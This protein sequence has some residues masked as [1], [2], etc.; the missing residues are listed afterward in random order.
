[1]LKDRGDTSFE[2]WAFTFN[3]YPYFDTSQQLDTPD[4]VTCKGSQKVALR[5]DGDGLFMSLIKAY[6]E[7]IATLD[8]RA[9]NGKQVPLWIGETG[10][11]SPMA[12][13]LTG[14]MKKCKDWSSPKMFARYYK[15]FLEWNLAST[16]SM[17]DAPP[18][19]VFY[20]SM[21]DSANNGISEMFGLV[22]GCDGDACKLQSY[23]LEEEEEEEEVTA[24]ELERVLIRQTNGTILHS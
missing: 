6:R 2:K 3:N 4:G 5:F 7:A 13:T 8:F 12:N 23:T 1:M 10:W 24:A 15:A 16:T 9:D 21:R 17:D 19:V 20:F 11:S 22:E 18:D 14:D